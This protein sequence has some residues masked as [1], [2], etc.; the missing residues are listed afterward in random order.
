MTSAAHE[1][2]PDHLLEAHVVVRRGDLAVD[3]P[4]RAAAG[5]VVAILGP[6]GAGKT[7]VLHALAGLA[8]L[9]DGHVTVDGE[10][11]AGPRQ[12]LTPD[13]RSVGLLAADHLL[14]P[15][16]SAWRNVAFGPIARRTGRAAARERA[17]DELAALGIADLADRKPRTLSHGQAQRVALARALATDP[18]L[19]LLDEPLS[20]LDPS[21]RPTVRAALATRLAAYDGVTVIVTHDP[22]DA[23]TLADRLVFLEGGRVVQEGPPR[24]IVE[25]PRNRYVA[26]VAGLNLYEGRARD[27]TTVRVGDLDIVTA[28]HDHEGAT[29]IA[30]APSAVSLYPQRPSGSPRNTWHLEVASIEL[31]GQTARV[32]CRGPIDLVAEIT[33]GSLAALRLHPGTPVWASVKAS[34]IRAYPA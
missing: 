34:E 5:E 25:H 28:E 6:N 10:S 20:A 14:F 9:H 3:V 15:H 19:L 29:W 13:Q 1:G 23:L 32:R 12:T 2:H 4:L 33:T 27:G 18:R 8:P 24:E 30:V 7:T 17:H 31:V 26:E 22:L 21:S 16:L 11:W